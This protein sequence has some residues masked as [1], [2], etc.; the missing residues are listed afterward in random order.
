MVF[1][2]LAALLGGGIAA[3]AHHEAS[4]EKG[5]ALFN[6]PKLGTTGKSC[7]D[8]HPGGKG[9]DKAAGSKD[10]EDRVNGC[11]SQALKGKELDEQSIE[12]K[13]M[14]LYI[15]SL[16]GKETQKNKKAAFGC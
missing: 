4:A 13:S 10:L 7:N 11:I 3:A 12:M 5:K 9:V 8:C 1:I 2:V 16:A 15:N 14:I 6:D